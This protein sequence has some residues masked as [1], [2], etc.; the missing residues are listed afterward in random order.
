ML[1]KR[2]DIQ[3]ILYVM[4]ELKDK[5][6]NVGLQYKFIKLKKS[7][8]DELAIYQEQVFD[9][10]KDFF[11]V[12]ENGDYV[13]SPEGGYAIQK[14][15]IKECNMM[16]YNLDNVDVQIPDMYLSLDELDG[17]GLSLAS[18]EILERFIKE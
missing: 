14:E 9:N 15:K 3:P 16:I 8:T 12:D 7:L 10:C 18:L 4:E 11:E 1:I 2:K 13:V 6:F 5:K 17:L